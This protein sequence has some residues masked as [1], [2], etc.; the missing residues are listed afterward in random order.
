[1]DKKTFSNQRV[2]AKLNG[3]FLIKINTDYNNKLSNKY[4]VYGLPTSMI[5][6]SNGKKIKR[7]EGFQEPKEFLKWMGGKK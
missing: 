2:K 1:M 3:Y 7:H 6:D 5:L 4:K